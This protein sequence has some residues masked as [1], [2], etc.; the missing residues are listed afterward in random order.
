MQHDMQ[1]VQECTSALEG[2][3]SKIE[4]EMGPLQHDLKAVGLETNHCADRI[5]D[6]ENR[7]RRNNVRILGLP[8]LMEG[9]NPTECIAQ[10][11]LDVFDRQNFTPFFAV[12]R[13]H[14]IPVRPLP[15]G[16]VPLL[17][18]REQIQSL[19]FPRSILMKSKC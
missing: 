1:K 11:L 5:D 19:L 6:L 4:N 10:W 9:R 2:R 18:S 16:N 7:L 12:E 3:V 13:A 14:R 8:E 15:L 17:S